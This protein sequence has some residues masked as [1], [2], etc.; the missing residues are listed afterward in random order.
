MD[1]GPRCW[2]SGAF[3]WQMNSQ[4]LS[5]NSEALLGRAF[6]FFSVV[7][8]WAGSGKVAFNSSGGNLL[9]SPLLI[10]E[11]G[12]AGRAGPQ[13][14]RRHWPGAGGSQAIVAQAS[15]SYAIIARQR[16]LVR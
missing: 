15:A 1:T 9:R 3:F 6:S 5:R 10:D 8:H 2:I 12:T 14:T 16:V 11:D 13:G 7:L 4:S